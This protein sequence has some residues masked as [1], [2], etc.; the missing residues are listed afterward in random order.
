MEVKE[1]TPEN[2]NTEDTDLAR[3][4]AMYKNLNQEQKDALMDQIDQDFQEA[5]L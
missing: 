3:I 4:S 5:E 1:P 2:Q